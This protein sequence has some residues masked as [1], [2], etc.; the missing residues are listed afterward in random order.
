ME[1][2]KLRQIFDL[3]R[4][5]ALKAPHFCIQSA[6]R[7]WN[8]DESFKHHCGFMNCFFFVKIFN[9]NSSFMLKLPQY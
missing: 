4:V 1:N 3:T 7:I 2:I 6:M 5:S 8:N 9:V